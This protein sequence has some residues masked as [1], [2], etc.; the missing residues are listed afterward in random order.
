MDG[1]GWADDATLPIAY[2]DAARLA[3]LNA[4][5]G[6]LIGDAPEAPRWNPGNFFGE[7]FGSR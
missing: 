2:A 3:A 6:R 1:S 4:R 7:R 5:I